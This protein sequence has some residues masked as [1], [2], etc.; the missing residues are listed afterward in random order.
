MKKGDLCK[1][2]VVFGICEEETVKAV[3]SLRAYAT[4][5]IPRKN[6]GKKAISTNNPTQIAL[7]L[8]CPCMMYSE[9]R[10]ASTRIAFLLEAVKVFGA[11]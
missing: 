9:A 2:T 8:S 10:N 4:Q 3:F 11:V 7:K 6:N 1:P 5:N